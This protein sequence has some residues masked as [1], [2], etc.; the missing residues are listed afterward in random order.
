MKSARSKPSSLPNEVACPSNWN[1]PELWNSVLLLKRLRTMLVPHTR[2]WF[3]L[4]IVQSCSSSR[5]PRPNRIAC[6]GALNDTPLP[7][8]ER[9]EEHTSELQSR[10]HLVCR[11]LLEKKKK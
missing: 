6:S 11:L 4:A 7:V 5:L 8:M 1:W 2:L 10:G 9:S 3:P